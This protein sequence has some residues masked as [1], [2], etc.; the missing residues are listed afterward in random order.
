VFL[1][2]SKRTISFSLKLLFSEL[3]PDCVDALKPGSVSDEDPLPELKSRKKRS[4]SNLRGKFNFSSTLTKDKLFN[5][6]VNVW[7]FSLSVECLVFGES[8]AISISGFGKSQMLSTAIDFTDLAPFLDFLFF[9]G[10][11]LKSKLS[12]DIAR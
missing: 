7:G 6:S 2:L 3:L 4:R 11:V 12:L 9:L 5:Y 10:L 8:I 1:V